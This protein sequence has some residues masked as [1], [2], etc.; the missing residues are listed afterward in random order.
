MEGAPFHCDDFNPC[1]GI[2][3]ATRTPAVSL[4]TPLDCDDGNACNGVE[5]CAPRTPAA[6]Q[7]LRW[8][9]RLPAQCQTAGICNPGTGTCSYGQQPN[10]TTCNDG[11]SWDLARHL[12]ER[13]VRRRVRLHEHAQPEDRGLLAEG[14]PARHVPR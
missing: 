14:L 8:S 9:A 10:G 3:T 13:H 1:N 11:N 5:T 2:E 6:S 7:A 12:S 4:G